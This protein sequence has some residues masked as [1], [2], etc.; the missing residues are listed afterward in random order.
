MAYKMNFRWHTKGTKFDVD[1]H[2]WHTKEHLYGTQRV[3]STG[4]MTTTKTEVIFG[5]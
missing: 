4:A 3:D 2:H 5:L 1:I